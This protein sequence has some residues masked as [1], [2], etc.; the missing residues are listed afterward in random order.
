MSFAVVSW[1][2]W[3]VLALLH[4]R[5]DLLFRRKMIRAAA[6]SYLMYRTTPIRKSTRIETKNQKMWWIKKH[7]GIPVLFDRDIPQTQRLESVVLNMKNIL[8]KGLYIN[9]RWASQN[10]SHHFNVGVIFST[11]VSN[12]K[13]QETKKRLK[14]TR[15]VLPKNDQPASGFKEKSFN[16]SKHV[17][18]SLEIFPTRRL[19]KVFFTF[20]YSLQGAINNC[21]GRPCG[22]PYAW[23]GMHTALFQSL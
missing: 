13:C 3:P 5:T 8:I 21:H 20:L 6:I 22:M 23:L 15:F 10:D 19:S 1:R 2:L 16:F 7:P 17:S 9:S 11:P 12:N 14:E 4:S 18:T